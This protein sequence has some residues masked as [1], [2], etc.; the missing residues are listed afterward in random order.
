MLQLPMEEAIKLMKVK[1][2]GLCNQ[3][4]KKISIGSAGEH[5]FS[6]HGAHRSTPDAHAHFW[7]AAAATLLPPLQPPIVAASIAN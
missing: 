5:D 6:P 4:E 7:S 3:K 1:R 2:C